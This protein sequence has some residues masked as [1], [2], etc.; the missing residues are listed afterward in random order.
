[1]VKVRRPGVVAQVN[2]EHFAANFT[3]DGR[4]HIPLVFWDTTTARV[5]TLER[6]R[7]IKVDDAAA[8][9]EAGID[10][11]ELARRPATSR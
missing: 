11:G 6:I 3:G 5:L 8:L 1:M 10:A 4:V 7:G 9:R 2:E